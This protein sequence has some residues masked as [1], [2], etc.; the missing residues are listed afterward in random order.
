[1]PSPLANYSLHSLHVTFFIL[2]FSLH[3]WSV[4]MNERAILES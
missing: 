4:R 1:M 2:T 3:A